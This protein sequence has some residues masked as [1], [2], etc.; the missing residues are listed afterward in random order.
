MISS[1]TTFLLP[2]L[3][4]NSILYFIIFQSNTLTSLPTASKDLAESPASRPAATSSR[5][6]KAGASRGEPLLELASAVI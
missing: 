5:G 6:Q 1:N 3:G 2:Q 4:T